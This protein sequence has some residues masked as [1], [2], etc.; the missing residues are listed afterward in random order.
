VPDMTVAAVDTAHLRRALGM[1]ATGVTIVATRA[2]S[3]EPV[4]LTV[5]SFSSVSLAPPLVLWSLAHKAA[6]YETF[7]ACATFSVSVLAVDQWQLAERFAR[8]GGDKF[9]GVAVRDGSAGMPLIEGAAAHFV[10]RVAA[11]HPGGDHDILIG[12]VLACDHGDRRPLIY[13][14]G[15][16]NELGAPI[17]RSDAALSATGS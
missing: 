17:D 3:G 16:F 11:R 14:R 9:A 2:A 13:T 7:A 8:S 10:C 12:E 5:N 15:Q 1:F 4:G 6:S